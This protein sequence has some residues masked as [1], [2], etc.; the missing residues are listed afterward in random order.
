LHHAFLRA[1]YSVG[2]TWAAISLLPLLLAGIGILL[3]FSTLPQYFGFYA[4]LSIALVYYCYIKHSWTSQRFLERH[5]IHHD[6]VI[7][8]GYV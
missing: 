7:E 3:E 6:F 2:D 4:F 1:G 8:D 5:F